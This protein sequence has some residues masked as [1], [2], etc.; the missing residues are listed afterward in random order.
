MAVK[1]SCNQ[2]LIEKHNVKMWK[3]ENVKIKK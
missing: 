2:E 3:Y 1:V